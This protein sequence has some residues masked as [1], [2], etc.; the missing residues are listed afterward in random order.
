MQY[1]TLV[2]E[3]TCQN[4]VC[5]SIKYGAASMRVLYFHHVG[6]SSD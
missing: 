2:F 3:N 4:V 1:I 5:Q 6:S